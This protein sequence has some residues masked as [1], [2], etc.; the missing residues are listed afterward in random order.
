MMSS[1][2]VRSFRSSDIYQLVLYPQG[3]LS[4]FLIPDS[5]NPKCR[6]DT[7]SLVARIL[8]W[9]DRTVQRID[10]NYHIDCCLGPW[11]LA[12]NWRYSSRSHRICASFRVLQ[13]LEYQLNSSLYLSVVSHRKLWQILRNVLLHC[14]RWIFDWG[15]NC[16]SNSGH[17]PWS[18]W[19]VDH[20]SW[21]L[22]CRRW[23]RIHCRK[24][25][26]Y[27]LEA[28]VKVL[29]IVPAFVEALG[30]PRCSTR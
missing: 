5:S 16:W 25:H 1:G 20:L 3:I 18:I 23:C 30:I 26:G 19:W 22:L 4:R 17:E 6:I 27:G 11:N 13:R 2:W 14:F 12:S 29:R 28:Q 24:G 15:S 10:Y 7:R 9:Q 8:C 21:C